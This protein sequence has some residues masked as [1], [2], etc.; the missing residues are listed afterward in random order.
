MWGKKMKKIRKYD[1]IDSKVVA[2]IERNIDELFA[3]YGFDEVRL[4]FNKFV[5]S[6]SEHKK[7]K[8]EADK[9]QKELEDLEKKM[10]KWFKKVIKK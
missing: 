6:V 9:K 8:A 5:K 3:D 10:D 7:L 2:R 1:D 4:V